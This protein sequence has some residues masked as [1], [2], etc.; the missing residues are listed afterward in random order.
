VPILAFFLGYPFPQKAYRVYNLSTH[1]ITVSRDIIFHESHFPFHNSNTSQTPFPTIY[2][3]TTTILPDTSSYPTPNPFPP[4][5]PRSLSTP[6]S[7]D[8]STFSQN[9]SQSQDTPPPL[10]PQSTHSSNSSQPSHPTLHTA[11][12]FLTIKIPPYY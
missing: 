9:L 1:T 6:S 4:S 10:S 11:H 12:L 5:D 7:Q 2:L 8:S 3:P